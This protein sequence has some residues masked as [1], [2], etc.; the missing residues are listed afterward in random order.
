MGVFSLSLFPFH[1]ALTPLAEV[2]PSREHGLRR[3]RVPLCASF[4][5]G[6]PRRYGL[7]QW[8]QRAM[9]GKNT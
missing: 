7:G 4:D 6:F 1:A 3:Q 5:A 9:V 2:T 8:R